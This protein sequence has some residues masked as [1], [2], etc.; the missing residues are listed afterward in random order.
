[1]KKIVNK[2]FV[3]SKNDPFIKNFSEG[4][5]KSSRLVESGFESGISLKGSDESFD[6]LIDKRLRLRRSLMRLASM[7]AE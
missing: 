1:M 4:M 2:P 6:G 3:G 7:K 5:T